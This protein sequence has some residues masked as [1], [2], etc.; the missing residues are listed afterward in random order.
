MGLKETGPIYGVELLDSLPLDGGMMRQAL[1]GRED[2]EFV[3]GVSERAAAG[4]EVVLHHYRRAS[5][6]VSYLDNPEVLLS[7]PQP[8]RMRLSE[9][10]H[11]H[12]EQS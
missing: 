2:L 12:E 1:P 3:R 7:I 5:R 6:V 11:G 9:L 10:M 8:H 4:Y